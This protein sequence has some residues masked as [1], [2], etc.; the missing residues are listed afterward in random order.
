MTDNPA[1]EIIIARHRRE[2]DRLEATV[3]NLRE[4]LRPVGLFK[5]EW[6]LS[7]G[8]TRGLALLL[9]RPQVSGDQMAEAVKLSPTS[10]PSPR[11]AAVVMSR[12]RKK[13]APD[14]VEI[15]NSRDQGYYLTD[16]SREIV[17]AALRVAD[18][19]EK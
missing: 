10:Y 13:L 9:R 1:L 16:K 8:E 11:T 5:P 12:V 18:D 14:G 6:Q 3:A 4:L 19:V 17:K 15:G 7:P 2:I